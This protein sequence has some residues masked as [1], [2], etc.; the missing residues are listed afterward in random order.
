MG[1]KDFRF[2]I[3]QVAIAII[4]MVLIFISFV[5]GKFDI[6]KKK[7]RERQLVLSELTTIGNRL[8]GIIHSTFNLTQGMVHLI[9][10]QGNITQN[11]F[12]SLC[13]M[14]M[15]ENRYIRNVAVAPDN[16][17]SM[18]YPL[19]GNEKALGLEY[20]KNDQQ[21]TS[22]LKAIELKQPL[23]AGPVN[24]VQG[25]VG[26]INR[27]P[28]YVKSS[29]DT[30]MTYWGVVSIVAY[31]D[32]MLYDAGIY[33]STKYQFALQGDDGKGAAGCVFYGDSILLSLDP[34]IVGI[35]IPSGKWQLIAIPKYGWANIP[36]YRSQ[37]FLFSIALTCLILT[38]LIVLIH[39]NNSIQQNNHLL[40]LEIKER[41]K[42]E[43][44]LKKSKE[45]AEEANRIKTVFLANMSHEIR[46]PMN[47]I[48]GFTEVLLKG[49]VSKEMT[50]E[51]TEIINTSSKQLLNVINDIIDISIIETGQFK[52]INENVGLNKLLNNI[53]NLHSNSASCKNIKLI[54]RF[55]LADNFDSIISDEHRLFQI[56]NNLVGNAIKFTDEGFVEFGYTLNDRNLQ[57]YV[58]DTGIGIPAEFHNL[59]F[60]RFRQVDEKLSRSYGGT[61]LGLAI[62]KSIVEL[63]HGEIWIES[64]SNVGSTFYFA[65]PYVRSTVIV[66][67]N[68]NYIPEVIKLNNKTIL[69]AEDDNLNFMLLKKLIEKTEA[70]ILRANNGQE[71]LDI[72]D[73]SDGVDLI[74]M[75]I[76]MP[77]MNGYEAT[78][79]IRKMK[80]MIP[81]VAQTAYA[82]SEEKQLA[83]DSGC[84][85]YITKPINHK[86]LFDLF[87]R[88]FG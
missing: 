7:G 86:E 25:G 21:K 57:F 54:V 77:I 9:R 15:L 60:E 38:F 23:L 72:L 24:L 53:Y 28:V 6:E 35:N 41:R 1:K 3:L 48:Q 55:G 88:I 76:K 44:E 31:Y 30:S 49:N 4:A 36:I 12:E 46:T 79:L 16:T 42:V 59:I 33:T 11:Q 26:L 17:I 68:N 29:T 75:D 50:T 81:I 47:A 56:I 84:D 32:S 51:F 8:E 5:I 80:K 40:A 74:L 87:K 19:I 45:A 27:S 22:V 82:M 69:V 64:E 52:I 14:A 71:V 63:M 39:I 18:I 85:Y 70:T 66:E 43:I 13:S 73:N 2:R 58:K 20:L 37:Y 62:C 10:F 83:F 65:F 67:P 78:A 34:I 61:G